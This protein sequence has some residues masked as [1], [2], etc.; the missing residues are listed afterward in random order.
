MTEQTQPET[1][2]LLW[3]AEAIGAFIGR[4]SRQTWEALHKGELPARQ[5][6]GRWCASKRRLTA[7]FEGEVAA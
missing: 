2:D 6:N 4:T 1:L 7:F 3:G 5:V